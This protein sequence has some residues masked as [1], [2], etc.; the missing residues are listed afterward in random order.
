M[1]SAG[2]LITGNEVLSAKT[3]DTN[4]PFI[5]MH[6]RRAGISVR[7]SMMCADNELDLLNCLRYLAERCEIIFM[8][9]GLGPTS[10]DLTAEVIAKFFNIP[11]QFNQEA[12]SSCADFFIKAGRSSIPESNKKQA[13]LPSGCSLLPNKLGTA[14]GFNVTGKVGE[15]KVTVYCMPGV[16]YEMEAMFLENVL[17]KL[18]KKS[19]SPISLFWQVFYMGESFMQ[20]AI[21]D[22]EKSLL[23]KFP[24]ASICYQAHSSYVTYSVTL[25]PNTQSEFDEYNNYL[26]SIF[27][28]SVENAFG[29]Y[30]MYRE[31]KKVASY[32]ITKLIEKKQSIS[33]V[34]TSC[35]GY[36][37][38]EFSL[39]SHDP[40]FF[41]GAIVANSNIIKKNV[42]RIS[43]EILQNENNDS[44]NLVSNLAISN[45]KLTNATFCLAEY[46]FPNDPY[47]KYTSKSEGFYLAIAISKEKFFNFSDVENK[48]ASFSWKEMNNIND[49]RFVVFSCFIK[50]NAR[51]VREVQ[52]M[53]AAYYLLC[54]LAKII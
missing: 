3:K 17:P 31:D 23:I 35:A 47:I 18:L 10:D 8:T 41:V 44:M 24:G 33:F 40:N 9:G 38:K 25:F 15:N 54:S 1:I 11:V 42:L 29:H 28:P 36:F 46:G 51:L 2:L 14:V 53:R 13:N 16:P 37:S 27:I 7:A 39:F 12:W 6:L 48:L 32:L 34:E 20:N 30:I 4:G 26:E 5:G 50:S 19:Y 43:D 45:L 21:N 52:Q 49:N 22:A